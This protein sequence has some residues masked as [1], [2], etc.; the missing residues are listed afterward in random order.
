MNF[1]KN[2]NL[3]ED[4]EPSNEVTEKEN[5]VISSQSVDEIIHQYKETE[6]LY[7]GKVK[8]MDWGNTARSGMSVSLYLEDANQESIHPFKGVKTGRTSGQRMKLFLIMDGEQDK[9]ILFDGESLLVHWQDDAVNGM[10]IKI[11]LDSSQDGTA[12]IHPCENMLTGEDGQTMFLV[13]WEIDDIEIPIKRKKKFVEMSAVSQSHILC[14]DINFSKYLKENINNI[15]EE[16]PNPLPDHINQHK[17][18]AEVIV[19]Q[20]CGV[21]TRAQFNGQDELAQN[22]TKK[23]TQLV[24]MYN[25]YRWK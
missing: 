9:G 7:N 23:W 1:K 22:A 15:L 8:L 25:E 19:R 3:F 6:P 5:R 14:R 18:F 4:E 10:Y 11:K 21:T 16:I 20:Y 17:A 12:G 13:C 24:N 2:I